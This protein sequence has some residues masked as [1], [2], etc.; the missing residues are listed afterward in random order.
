VN[1]SSAAVF[2][3]Q[4]RGAALEAHG[5][6]TLVLLDDG[7]PV[8]LYYRDVGGVRLSPARLGDAAPPLH[9][10]LA[11]DDPEALRTKLFAALAVVLGELAATLSAEYGTDPAVVWAPAAQVA[12]ETATAD[13]AAL[14]DPALPVK[15]TT[16]MRLADDP[17]T[18]IWTTVPNPMA[19]LA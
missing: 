11:T 5:Q 4:H 15:A 10:D 13:A 18:D 3:D 1:S 19:G 17:L 12:R 8:R 7:R 2:V 6:N 16:A 9:G 14:F